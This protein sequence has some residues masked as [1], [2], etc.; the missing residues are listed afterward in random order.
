MRRDYITRY[1]EAVGK[2]MNVI[3][4]GDGG[5]PVVVF[6]V[7]DAK[8]NNFEDFGMIDV[9][10]DYIESGTLQLFSIDSIDEESWSD[11]WGD[12]AHR[13]Q[14]QEDY[15]RYVTDEL[16]P[17][18][19]E[20]NGTDRRPLAID[21]S[22]CAGCNPAVSQWLDQEIAACN[23][24]LEKAGKASI[25]LVH[26]REAAPSKPKVARRSFFRSLLSATA[27]GV[28]DFTAAQT[29]RLYAFDPVIWLEK[30]QAESC[31]L[32]PA[33]TV[34]GSCN[35]CG[36]CAMLCPEKA[37]T[38]TDDPASGGGRKI[39]FTPLRCTACAVCT[40]NCPHN[41]LTLSAKEIPQERM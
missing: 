14:R 3:V 40:G 2:D 23:Q 8:C 26:V 4:Y 17:L 41:A 37:I 28:A 34:S 36:L 6:Q 16:I 30:Q 1:S 25:R 13:A 27:Q 32:F 29:E 38:I 39:Q 31:N 18:V 22:H 9:L 35:F 33:L 7:Q 5:Y 12:K 20:I 21:T 24:A 19:H 10:A 15:F 11:T